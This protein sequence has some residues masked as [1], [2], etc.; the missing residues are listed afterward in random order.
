M[1]GADTERV[2]DVFINYKVRNIEKAECFY[3]FMVLKISMEIGVK[4]GI[5]GVCFFMQNV[6]TFRTA[7]CVIRAIIRDGVVFMAGK[8]GTRQ[9]GGRQGRRGI[10]RK[11]V[12]FFTAHNTQT[13]LIGREISWCFFQPLIKLMPVQDKGI[14]ACG[15]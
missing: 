10:K 8:R 7:L 15:A 9:T 11:K 6:P 1:V 5:E 3:F 4:S 2:L 14:I 13:C 12:T